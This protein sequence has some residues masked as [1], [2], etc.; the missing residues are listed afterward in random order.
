MSVPLGT[1]PTF[2]LE[3]G[4]QSGVDLTSAVHVYVTMESGLYS[5]TKSDSELTIAEKSVSVTLTQEE[6][7]QMIGSVSLQ[8]N[9]TTADGKRL[10]SEVT[11]CDLSQQLLMV[12][13]E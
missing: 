2:V 9:W 8:V 3:F 1:T 6:S 13:V 10:A 5:L 11:K 12:V 4:A 7:L